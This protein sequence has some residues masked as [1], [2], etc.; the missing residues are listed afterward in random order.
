[1]KK[2]AF[3]EITYMQ[4]I[5]IIHGTQIGTGVF[6]LPK[7]LA[8]KAGTDGWM[9]LLL[10][11]GFAVA[12]SIAIVQIFKKFPNDTLADLLIRLFGK[13]IGKALLIPVIL[14]FAFGVWSVLTSGV[15]YVKH[16][17]L[18]QTSDY[19]VMI[20]LIVPGYLVARSGL[21]ILGRYSELV[22]YMTLWMPFT[23]LIVLK[24]SHWIHLL[25]LFKDGWRPIV[26]GVEETAF[27]FFGFEIVY[28]LYPFLQ[29]KQLAVRG[30]VIAN[31]LTLIY[32]LGVTLICFAFYSPDD[33]TNYNQPLLSLLKV[34]E[35]RFLERFDMIYLVFYLF[36]VST[37]WL[38]MTF[39]AVF[40]TGHLFGKEGPAPFA[41]ILFLLI[42]ALTVALHPSWN[43]LQQSQQLIS[44]FGIGFAYILPWFLLLYSRIY[45]RLRRRDP[46]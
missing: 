31:T 45:D 24:D 10:G 26:Q 22:F 20:L 7:N 40:S 1:M 33:I 28:F 23:L 43:Q 11:W 38:S 6:S 27:S 12:A 18:P 5:L 25:P 46:Q 39:G 2:Y 9:S 41:V 3:N 15:L 14:Y 42:V 37:T 4:F 16:W 13:F 32:Y 44:K 29:K 19:V 34:I 17:F 30:V 8:E 36:V 35:L 21:R